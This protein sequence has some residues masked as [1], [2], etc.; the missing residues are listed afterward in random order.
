VK[1]SINPESKS[2]RF[3][4]YFFFFYGNLDMRKLKWWQ[5]AFVMLVVQATLGDYRDW[6]F[7]NRWAKGLGITS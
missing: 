7:I 1:K 2:N 6:E 4:V 5:A 3:R